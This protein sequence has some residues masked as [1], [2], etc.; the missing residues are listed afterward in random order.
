M[1]GA[2]DH[3]NTVFYCLNHWLL[4]GTED[5]CVYVSDLSNQGAQHQRLKH[6]G[7]GVSGSNNTYDGVSALI[8][9]KFPIYG[10][11]CSEFIF[12]SG[13]S[14]GIIKA[15][16][17][18]AA[19]KGQK[20][21][22][23]NGASKTDAKNT[24]Y[25]GS[26]AYWSST[27]S[28]RFH[29]PVMNFKLHSHKLTKF[30][31]SST[32]DKWLLA[33]GDATGSISISAGLVNGNAE[34]TGAKS[35]IKALSETGTSHKGKIVSGVTTRAITCLA[36][37]ESG[38][39]AANV[40][41][42]T[43]QQKTALSYQEKMYSVLVGDAAGCITSIDV[44][45]GRANLQIPAAHESKVKQIIVIKDR[46]FLSSGSDRSIKLWD[47]RVHYRVAAHM[48]SLHLYLR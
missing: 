4:T 30:A 14:H 10:P 12:F 17:L 26:S 46:Q 20:H 2:D 8:G 25:L 38:G 21:H 35:M 7:A 23:R 13:C 24:G 42:K 40:V 39:D 41:D 15:W 44:E 33:A 34:P 18:P 3:N 47:L 16:L 36:F 27:L 19:S 28:L 22:P 48:V 11:K 6:S 43:A 45:T 5:G 37:L 31:F 32:G 9:S 29:Q 1:Q